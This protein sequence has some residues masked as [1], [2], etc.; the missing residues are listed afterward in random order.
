M[1]TMLP[2]ILFNAFVV[3]MLLLDL[4]VFHRA[5]HEVKLKEALTWSAVWIALALIF[6]VWLYFDRGRQ[7]AVEFLTGYIL[8]KSLS[9]D[10]LFVFIMIFAR[11]GVA[12]QYQHRILFW[13]ILGALVMR[14][15]FI[16]AGITLIS[17]FHWII[18]VFGAFLVYTGVKMWSHSG[19]EVHPEQNPLVQFAVR[20]LPFTGEPAEGRFF[21]K[22]ATGT[23]ATRL[24]LVLLMIEA[25][26]LVFAVDSI[27]A[28]IAITRDP[29]IVYTSNIFAILGLRA[30]YFAL[31]GIMKLFHRLHYGLSILLCYV[32]IKML[33]SGFFKI[34]TTASLLIIFSILSISVAASV[35]YPPKAEEAKS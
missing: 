1:E 21:I 3:A 2:W 9:V 18:Y 17:M 25:T 31:A 16:F 5:A 11:F 27:P 12:P 24:F 6:N 13:G 14:A 15:F 19:E 29:F 20:R 35:M 26:D 28:V 33:V 22:T 34:P 7:P 23:K 10:N 8:E 32:G 4:K 30:L